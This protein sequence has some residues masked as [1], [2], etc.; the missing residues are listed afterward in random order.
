MNEPGDSKQS[1]VEADPHPSAASVAHSPGVVRRLL[2]RRLS[3]FAAVLTLG[4]GVAV[5]A[6]VGPAPQPSFAGTELPGLLGT[7]FGHA[8]SGGVPG[9]NRTPPASEEGPPAV[10]GRRKRHRRKRARASSGAS[11]SSAPAESTSP[12]ASSTPTGASKAALQ[13]VTSVWLIELSGESFAQALAQPAAAPYIDAQ[14]IPAGT[15]ESSWTALDGSAFASDAALAGLAAPVG[16]PSPIVQQIVQPPCPE[17]TAASAQ[18]TPGT[19]GQLTAADAFAKQAISVIS[20]NSL[21]RAHGLILVTFAAVAQAS[22]AGLPEGA[23]SSTLTTQPPAGVLLLSPFIR[24]GVRSTSTFDS[25][26][27]THALTA[28]LGR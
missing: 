13:P 4:T 14:L 21:Y 10:E 5:G 25:T 22:A 7:L 11:S 23:A 16:S 20:A 26:S 9:A 18:C 12:S 19:P 27:P 2:K 3:V 24:A 15:L 8:A 28:L 1:H 17:G 6:A